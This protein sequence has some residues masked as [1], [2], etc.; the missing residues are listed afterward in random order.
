M[1]HRRKAHLH[2][3]QFVIGAREVL[4]SPDWKL[5]NLG[6]GIRLSFCPEL[7]VHSGTDSRGEAWV[8]L[9][10]AVQSESRQESPLDQLSR[11]AVE[12]AARS[13][14]HWSGRWLLI[15]QRTVYT[16][17]SALFGCLYGRNRQGELWVS[18]SAAL[19]AERLE[20]PPDQVMS[21][22]PPARWWLPPATGVPG[23][24]RLLPSQTLSLDDG[25]LRA[26]SLLP[27]LEAVPPLTVEAQIASRLTTV[28]KN[29]VAG[30]GTPWLALTAGLDS[31]T[32]LAA[33]VA[34]G[35]MPKT[36]TQERLDGE[37]SAADV[38]LPPRLA[39][40]V[41][42]SHSWCPARANHPDLADL[43]TRHTA[44]QAQVADKAFFGRDQFSFGDD[45]DVVLRGGCFELGRRYY[46]KKLVE[47]PEPQ[48]EQIVATIETP[49]S[50]PALAAAKEWCDW[51]TAHPEPDLDW[52]DRLYL[53]GRLAGWLSTIEQ[54]LDLIGKRLLHPMKLCRE[55]GLAFPHSAR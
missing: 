6:A 49:D 44:A 31:R 30:S 54:S 19:L 52:R 13:M 26:R 24:R 11:D 39:R 55:P 43:Y 15:K 40:S 32:L 4:A 50:E 38:F 27:V 33:A 7:P 22:P 28:I 45:E 46:W 37:M 2:R 14:F 9:G 23:G 10:W 12:V 5:L 47:K 18:S 41:G 8:L 42:C 20:C 53:E 29:A 34:S 48:P 36:Y 21:P 3:R 16:D 1:A 17:A 25:S 51:V 35:I